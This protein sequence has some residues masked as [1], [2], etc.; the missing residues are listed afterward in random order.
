M[1]KLAKKLREIAADFGDDDPDNRYF[2]KLLGLSSGRISQILDPDETPSLG[3]K[4]IG[5]LVK[6][7][8]SPQW[9]TDESSDKLLANHVAN[10]QE[11]QHSRKLVQRLC[12]IAETINDI[13][14]KPLIE[15]AKV[16]AQ[17]YPYKSVR[18]KRAKAA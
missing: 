14:L 4:S 16:T 15:M 3:A 8:Y 2:E 12:E 1:N 7:G 10:H 6:L 5:K 11:A 18:Q 9:L 13:G 17:T